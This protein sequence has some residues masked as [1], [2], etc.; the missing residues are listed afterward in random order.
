VMAAADSSDVIIQSASER[1]DVVAAAAAAAAAANHCK[2]Q[3]PDTGSLVGDWV[4]L[5]APRI[6]ITHTKTYD[7]T[8]HLR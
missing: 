7:V 5:T 8:M 4:T 1:A 3:P 2:C 6:V